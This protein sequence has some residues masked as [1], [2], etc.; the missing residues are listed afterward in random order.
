MGDGIQVYRGHLNNPQES[1]LYV[2]FERRLWHPRPFRVLN[3]VICEAKEVL[4][5]ILATPYCRSQTLGCV[6]SQGY[7]AESAE[8]SQLME[9]FSKEC[10]HNGAKRRWN[11]QCLPSVALL[12]SILPLMHVDIYCG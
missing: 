1:A 7:S 4:L 8:S 6:P 3:G 5:Q 9:T 10:M 11:T 12:S 2:H